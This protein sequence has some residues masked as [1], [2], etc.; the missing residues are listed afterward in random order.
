MKKNENEGYELL[1]DIVINN[2]VW[3]KRD[4]PKKVDEIH[5]VDALTNLEAQV[6]F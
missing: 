4:P 3:L 2:Y 1:E 6:A 5:E